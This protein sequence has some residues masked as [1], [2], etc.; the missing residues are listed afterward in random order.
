MLIL[1]KTGSA[2]CCLPHLYQHVPK[3]LRHRAEMPTLLMLARSAH[4]YAGGLCPY[5]QRSYNVA[6]FRQERSPGVEADLGTPYNL[7]TREYHIRHVHN[8]CTLLGRNGKRVSEVKELGQSDV[9][10]DEPDCGARAKQGAEDETEYYFMHAYMHRKYLSCIEL[11]SEQ[12]WPNP[13]GRIA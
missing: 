9:Q 6:A 4:A 3:H 13:Y 2:F 11:V 8:Y 10:E 7:R 12:P 5:S 1:C